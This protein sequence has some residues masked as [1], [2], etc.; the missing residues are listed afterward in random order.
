MIN[1]TGSGST[2]N[3][4]PPAVSQGNFPPSATL[5]QP[6]PQN[7]SKASHHYPPPPTLG[8]YQ[9]QGNTLP[10]IQPRLPSQAP[11]PGGSHPFSSVPP[12]SSNQGLAS[13]LDANASKY[14]TTVFSLLFLKHFLNFKWNSHWF[15]VFYLLNSVKGKGLLRIALRSADLSGTRLDFKILISNKTNTVTE[16]KYL[17][18]KSGNSSD[19]C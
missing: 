1:T 7:G 19:E 5:T 9:N 17:R 13:N 14:C 6:P 18:Q 4:R 15:Q 10:G 11:L 8:P 2:N 16:H 3:F 12:G